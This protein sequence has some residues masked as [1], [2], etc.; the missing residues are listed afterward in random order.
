MP[1]AKARRLLKF[2]KSLI[3]LKDKSSDETLIQTKLF[4]S[5]LVVTENSQEADLQGEKNLIPKVVELQQEL[6]NS[7]TNTAELFIAGLATQYPTNL[8]GPE[9]TESFIRRWSDVE[10]NIR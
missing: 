3:C 5:S 4:E 8:A 2:F 9:A 6:P 7:Q 1:S 10:S